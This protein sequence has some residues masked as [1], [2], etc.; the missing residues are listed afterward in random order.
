M[1]GDNKRSVEEKVSS[2]APDPVGADDA[3][4]DTDDLDDDHVEIQKTISNSRKRHSLKNGDIKVQD[5]LPF[6][7]LPNI[8]PLTVSDLESCV[9][10]ENAA[11]TDSKHR[12]SREKFEYRLSSC[13]ELCMGIFCTVSPEAAKGWEIETCKTA[14]PVETGRD[15]GSV[16]VMFAHIVGTRCHGELVTDQDM[17]YPRDFRTV[18]TS[19]SNIGHQED[20]RTVAIHSLAVHP[21]L[22]GCGLGKLIM[23]AYMQQVNNSGTADRISLIS[24]SY[25]VNYYT[26]FG[27]VHKGESQASFGGGGWHDLTITLSGPSSP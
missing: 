11:F 5:V 3:I 13:P 8:R 4:D 21:K 17:D 9:A 6:P 18:K 27:F 23:K 2:S 10:L 20:G 12:C 7:F 25:L 24:Q 26:R 22:Q 1:S 14:H 16:S 15:D 19:R